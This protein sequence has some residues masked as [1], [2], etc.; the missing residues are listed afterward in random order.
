[1]IPNGLLEYRLNFN[2]QNFDDVHSVL[3]EIIL[4]Q[5]RKCF[6]INRYYYSNNRLERKDPLVTQELSTKK[7]FGLSL[8]V[9]PNRHIVVHE[10]WPLLCI[11]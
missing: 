3:Q 10:L 4:D 7:Q 11:V 1:M 9:R 2:E 6:F 5:G 8:S